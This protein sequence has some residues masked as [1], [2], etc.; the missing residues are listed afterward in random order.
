M[1]SILEKPHL[2]H[3]MVDSSVGFINISLH[4]GIE[5]PA[6]KRERD[7]QYAG[8]QGQRLPLDDLAQD[9]HLRYRQG[10]DAHHQRQGGADGDTFGKHGLGH[11]NHPGGIRV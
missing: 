10:R 2:E 3:V 7:C 11:R 5:A 6:D 1:A 8:E 9:Q 4:D